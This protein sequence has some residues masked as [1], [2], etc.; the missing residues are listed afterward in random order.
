MAANEFVYLICQVHFVRLSSQ[1][2]IDYLG[3]DVKQDMRTGR[4]FTIEDNRE[5]LDAELGA[6]SPESKDAISSLLGYWN[7]K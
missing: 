1:H 7:K 3:F 5:R 2:R 4:V 6:D